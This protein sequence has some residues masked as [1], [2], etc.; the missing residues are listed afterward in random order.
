M[1]SPRERAGSAQNHETVALAALIGLLA[2]TVAWWAL[3]LWPVQSAPTWLERTRFVCFG[4]TESGLPDTTGWIGLIG[5]PLG[6]LGILLAGWWREFAALMRKARVSRALAGTLLAL[7]SVL[8]LMLSG[9][10]YRVQQAGAARGPSFSDRSQQHAVYPRLDRAAPALELTAHDG[11][12]RSLAEFH[13]RPLLVTF[14]FGHCETICPL[15]VQDVLA[16][17]ARRRSAGEGPVVLIVTLDPWRD[18]PSRLPHIAAAW[19]L[20]DEDVW[21]LGGDVDD[22]E[23]TLDAWAVGRNRSTTSGDVTHSSLVY[24]I[25]HDGRIAFAAVGDPATLAALV[26]RL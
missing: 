7:A 10:G 21:L 15:I 18:T 19:G 13:G 8:V 25:D 16:A 22:V 12:T 4:V 26:G 1:V 5:A 2:I 24:V 20:P 11:T 3:A 6:M 14:A 23:A 9:A 17:Q